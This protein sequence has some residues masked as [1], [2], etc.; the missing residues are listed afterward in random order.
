MVI[1]VCRFWEIF[2]PRYLTALLI[3]DDTSV[4]I[5]VWSE[6]VAFW[7]LLVLLCWLTTSLCATQ[8]SVITWKSHQDWCLLYKQLQRV[9]FYYYRIHTS[10]LSLTTRAVVASFVVVGVQAWCFERIPDLCQPSQRGMF[11]SAWAQ[12]KCAYD[13]DVDHFSCPQI[14]TFGIASL[15]FGMLSE[16]GGC[17]L[18][19][20]KWP[21]LFL[22]T[23]GPSRTF[24]AGAL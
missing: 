16:H 10:I 6:W 22:G 12:F 19:N 9:C 18:K 8:S 2:M 1:L 15:I 3:S 13:C 4:V 24:S 14:R 5:C 20:V 11:R 21:S 7:L 17:Q 23:S